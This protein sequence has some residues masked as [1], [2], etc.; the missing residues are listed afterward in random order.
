M[1][2]LVLAVS[3]KRFDLLVASMV[4]VEFLTSLKFSRFEEP[5]LEPHVIRR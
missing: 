1:Y 2:G 5:V 3:M 4:L